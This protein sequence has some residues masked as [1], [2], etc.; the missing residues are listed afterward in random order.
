V[1]LTEVNSDLIL[2]SLCFVAAVLGG[3][4]FP[5]EQTGVQYLVEGASLTLR[6]YADR[7][8]CSSNDLMIFLVEPMKAYRK[9]DVPAVQYTV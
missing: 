4:G 7:W 1:A 9:N 3:V 2:G 5:E 6:C 8:R